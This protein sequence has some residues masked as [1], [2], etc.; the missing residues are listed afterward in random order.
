MKDAELAPPF[1][2]RGAPLG[3]NLVMGRSPQGVGR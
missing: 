2:L 1:G 3:F